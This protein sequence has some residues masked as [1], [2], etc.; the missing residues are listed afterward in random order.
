MNPFRKVSVRTRLIGLAAG[1]GMVVV[2]SM[3]EASSITP[4]STVFME[5]LKASEAEIWLPGWLQML[6]LDELQVR[7]VIEI[8]A[9][10]EQRLQSILTSDQ[11]SQWRSSQI[12]LS[13]ATEHET[14]T[15][16]DIDIDLSSYQQVAVDAT[17]KDAMESVIAILSV[18]QTQQLLQY[19]TEEN[20]MTDFGVGI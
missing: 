8:D 14:W 6:N 18:E 13:D 17:F 16:A 1:V 19:L 9:V 20:S 4:A 2:S 15:F 5:D 12:N 10:L 11:Y 3:V 7:Q